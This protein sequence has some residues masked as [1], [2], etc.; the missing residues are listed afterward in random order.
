MINPVAHS[1][2]AISIT[3]DGLANYGGA[4]SYNWIFIRLNHNDFKFSEVVKLS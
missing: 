2:F 4:F 3:G 1:L